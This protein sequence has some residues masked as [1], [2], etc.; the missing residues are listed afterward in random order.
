MDHFDAFSEQKVLHKESKNVRHSQKSEW[1]KARDEWKQDH[2]TS[3]I[4]TKTMR[5]L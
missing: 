4:L 5:N 3:C 2:K 1:E